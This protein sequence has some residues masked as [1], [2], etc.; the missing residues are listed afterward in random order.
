[1]H[2]FLTSLCLKVRF[3]RESNGQDLVEYAL[4]AALFMLAAA[5]GLNPVAASVNVAFTNIGSLLSSYS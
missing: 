3:F 1:M 2:N 5:A 4:V